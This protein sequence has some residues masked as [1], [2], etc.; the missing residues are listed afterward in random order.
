MDKL[1]LFV[2]LFKKANRVSL[3]ER[4][5]PFVR[6]AQLNAVFINVQRAYIEL[7]RTSS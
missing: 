7:N 6:C 1:E 2:C 5:L 4:V 3:G